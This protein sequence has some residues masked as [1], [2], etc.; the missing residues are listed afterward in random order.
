MGEK[1]RQWVD[2][3]SAAEARPRVVFS[4]RMA[5]FAAGGVRSDIGPTQVWTQ[6]FGGPNEAFYLATPEELKPERQAEL[7]AKLAQKLPEVRALSFSKGVE[8]EIFTHLVGHIDSYIVQHHAEAMLQH[9]SDLVPAIKKELDNPAFREDL[10]SKPIT[11]YILLDEV[12]EHFKRDQGK[13][14]MHLQEVFEKQGKKAEFA[15]AVR[16]ATVEHV[17]EHLQREQVE[18]PRADA[19]AKAMVVM[20]EKDGKPRV[21]LN[22]EPLETYRRTRLDAQYADLDAAIDR[23]RQNIVAQ[24]RFLGITEPFEPTQVESRKRAKI[25]EMAHRDIQARPV[26]LAG[27]QAPNL[28]ILVEPEAEG[29]STGLSYGRQD[30]IRVSEKMRNGTFYNVLL[31]ELLHTGV[32]KIYN[33]WALPFC[34]DSDNRKALL[35]RALSDDQKR[36]QVYEALGL[37]RWANYNPRDHVAM[38]KEAPVKMLKVLNFDEVFRGDPEK[39]IDPDE[40]SKATALREFATKAIIPDAQAYLRGEALPALGDDYS[41]GVARAKGAGEGWKKG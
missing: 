34:D 37:T 11:Y 17:S 12:F 28:T 9:F 39:A 8:R 16:L 29:G 3:V 41:R 6:G 22:A 36:V 40:A 13:V 35:E 1:N 24:S 30:F 18:K 21:K 5:V 15:E 19:L 4:E 33:N 2:T 7:K 38:M 32:D 26:V 20:A 14:Y 27:Y 10:K 31:E 23:A 25:H